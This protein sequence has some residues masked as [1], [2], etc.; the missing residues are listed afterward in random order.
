MTNPNISHIPTEITEDLTTK[1]VVEHF[2][3]GAAKT[4]SEA[5]LLK[6]M[7]ADG[8]AHNA[9]EARV[10]IGLPQVPTEPAAPRPDGTPSFTVPTPAPVAAAVVIPPPPHPSAPAEVHANWLHGIFSGLASFFASPVGVALVAAL[11]PQYKVG[12]GVAEAGIAIGDS[13]TGGNE[14]PASTGAE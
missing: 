5:D 7:V 4:E 14:S 3:D 2:A 10:E 1:T 11:P 8:R 12:V 6:E 9:N 13:L